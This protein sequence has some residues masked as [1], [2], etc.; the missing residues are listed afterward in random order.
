MKIM[1]NNNYDGTLPARLVYEGPETKSSLPMIEK[2]D[3]LSV[4]A[5]VVVKPADG[6][7]KVDSAVAG[8][9]KLEPQLPVNN[10][11]AGS[12]LETSPTAQLTEAQIAE[13]KARMM[14]EGT[15]AQASSL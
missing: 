1:H 3:D 12:T 5:E 8:L 7:K 6:Q 4:G 2:K 13:A 11:A 9:S 14:K 10:F 15:D